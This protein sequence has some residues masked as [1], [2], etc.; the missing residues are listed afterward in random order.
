MGLH[1]LVVDDSDLNLTVISSLLNKNSIS[2][3]CVTS[4]IDAYS[5]LECVRYDMIMMDYLMPD[6]NG[7]E[8]S[9]YI[10]NMF[11][12]S[13]DENYYE[14][15]P[16]VMLTAEDNFDFAIGCNAN[17][18]DF[19]TKPATSAKLL[20]LIKKY[21]PNIDLEAEKPKTIP[22]RIDGIDADPKECLDYLEIFVNTCDGIAL[23][24][25]MALHISDYTTYTIEVHRLKGEAQIIS[26]TKLSELAREL[27]AAGKSILKTY[28]NGK[29]EEENISTIAEKTPILLKTLDTLKN[30]IHNY[31][32]ANGITTGTPTPAT[33]E[34]KEPD[35]NA[36]ADDSAKLIISVKQ[37]DKA[38][39]Y[40]NYAIE[41]IDAGDP[42]NA[43]SW[44]EGIKDLLS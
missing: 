19:L 1:F 36:L 9:E 13:F 31:K 30:D 17:I 21:F 24:I 44:L 16:I 28:D 6:V 2:C 5:K 7:I 25:K 42:M 11:S 26:A 20:A 34:I 33:S 27:E 4:P 38:V 18:K 15:I 40:I 29:S 32:L 22:D 14:N 41:S 43:R 10:R 12:A 23:T 37:R 3:D 39:R 8:A 35:K